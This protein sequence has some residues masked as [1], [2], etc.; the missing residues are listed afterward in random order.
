MLCQDPVNTSNLNTKAA[1]LRERIIKSWGNST[2]SNLPRLDKVPPE[3]LLEDMSTALQTVP[4][5][6]ITETNRLIY[7][8]A[9]VVL[10][11]LGYK[12]NSIKSNRTQKEQEHSTGED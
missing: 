1:D 3:S 11:M 8:A 6:T 2:T 4:T 7:A 12:M 10:E 5:N 9:A